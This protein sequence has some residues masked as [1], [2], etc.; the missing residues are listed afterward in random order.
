MTGNPFLGWQ[1]KSYFT[2][3]ASIDCVACQWIIKETVGQ[4]WHEKGVSG[5]VFYWTWAWFS[6]WTIVYTK[7]DLKYWK[8]QDILKRGLLFAVWQNSEL[9]KKGWRWRHINFETHYIPR[10]YGSHLLAFYILCAFLN[11]AQSFSM[12]SHC[13]LQKLFPFENF[14]VKT[15]FKVK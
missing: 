1:N 8:R 15:L 3:F 11:C 7:W 2:W 6:I 13:R 5:A 4:K 12:L 14:F 9:W 10:M